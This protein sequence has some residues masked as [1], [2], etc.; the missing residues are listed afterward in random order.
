VDGKS[1]LSL[2]NTLQ[3]NVVF[4]T[5]VVGY[6]VESRSLDGGGGSSADVVGDYVDFSEPRSSNKSSS[7]NDS[8]RKIYCGYD[9]QLRQQP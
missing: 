5:P 9:E 1:G 3:L 8:Q 4:V 7:A 2:P 6:A